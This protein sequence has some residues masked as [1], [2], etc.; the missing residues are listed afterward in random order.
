MSIFGARLREWER[1][2]GEPPARFEGPAPRTAL[3]TQ[4]GKR[5]KFIEEPRFERHP[6]GHNEHDI[7]M[8][9]GVVDCESAAR[10]VF[11][12]KNQSSERVRHF[13]SAALLDAKYGVFRTP[14]PKIPNHIS[15]VC[16]PGINPLSADAKAWWADPNRVRLED[17]ESDMIA[18]E[19]G[20][21]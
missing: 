10:M 4:L 5:N 3:L 9:E 17:L 15:V 14:F 16:E 6:Q 11:G 21:Q 18:M 19:S 13:T 20:R 2:L 12:R 8:F 7:S 1:I